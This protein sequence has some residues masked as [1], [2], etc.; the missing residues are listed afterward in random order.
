MVIRIVRR[1]RG[2]NAG[3]WNEVW[4]AVDV[5]RKCTSENCWQTDDD[6]ETHLP[7]RTDPILNAIHTLN[8]PLLRSESAIQPL[9]FYRFNVVGRKASN[10]QPLT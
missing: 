7:I 8:C 6:A 2:S 9:I 4:L 5:R 10:A 1:I 3:R